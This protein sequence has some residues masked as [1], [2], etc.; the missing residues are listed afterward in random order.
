[1]RLRPTKIGLDVTL[2]WG[3]T[4]LAFRRID[5]GVVTI[6]DLGPIPLPCEVHPGFAVACVGSDTATFVAPPGSALSTG[7][8]VGAPATVERADGSIEARASSRLAEGDRVEI[9][10]GAFRIE[11]VAT[12]SEVIDAR[13]PWRPGTAIGA[14]LLAAAVHAGV[15]WIAAEAAPAGAVE[16]EDA[17]VQT[18]RRLLAA[19]PEAVPDRATLDPR[20]ASERRQV[21]AGSDSEGAR[22]LSN[23]WPRD[24]F[25]KTREERRAAASTGTEVDEPAEPAARRAHAMRDA[26]GFGMVGLIMGLGPATPWVVPEPSRDSRSGL[27]GPGLDEVAGAGLTR[28]GTGEGSGRSGR[29]VDAGEISVAGFPAYREREM[30]PRNTESAG[31][32]AR[33]DAASIARMGA[34]AA[35]RVVGQ[36]FGRMRACYLTQLR[37]NPDLAGRVTV[38][39]EIGAAGSVVRTSDAGSTLPPAITTCVMRAVAALSFAA[40]EGGHLTVTYP[41]DFAPT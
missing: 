5:E 4:A 12:A 35:Q 14:M 34:E 19:A 36:N 28:S 21:D 40:P 23:G 15:L 25:A 39:F 8:P 38:R 17:Q 22:S 3:D 29:G 24:P 11:V 7:S 27:W 1:M 33:A 32:L 31:F 6:D 9:V 10:L 37:T 20:A 16:L 13:A 30:R 41:M 2:L 26:G 18:L